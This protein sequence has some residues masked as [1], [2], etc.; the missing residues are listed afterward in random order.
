MTILARNQRQLRGLQL[1]PK[2]LDLLLHDMQTI[3]RFNLVVRGWAA[4]CADGEHRLATWRLGVYR[5]RALRLSMCQDC[6]TVEVRDITS[7]TLPVVGGAVNSRN[8]LLGWYSGARAAG[9]AHL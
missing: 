3:Q 2:T 6:E 1:L 8:E 5:R 9:R 7:D 4:A